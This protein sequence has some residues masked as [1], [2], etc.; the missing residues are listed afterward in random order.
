MVAT[1]AMSMRQIGKELGVSQPF[2]SQ[3]KAGKRPMPEHLKDKLEAMGAYH[4]LIS[5]KQNEVQREPEVADSRSEKVVGRVG[6]EPTTPGLK[7]RC[8]TS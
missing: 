3:I 1:K 7:V 8:S 5:D 4:L 6:I 2:L